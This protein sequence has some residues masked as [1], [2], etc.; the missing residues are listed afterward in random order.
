MGKGSRVLAHSDPKTQ[1][2]VFFGDLSNSLMDDQNPSDL[3]V[4]WPSK[5]Y[6]INTAGHRLVMDIGS[7]PLVPKIQGIG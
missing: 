7:I 4:H 3:D 5:V 1:V 6:Q 2:P